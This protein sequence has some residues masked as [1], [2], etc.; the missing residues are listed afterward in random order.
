MGALLSFC[1]L[2]VF[3]VAQVEPESLADLVLR[4]VPILE[5]CETR[6]HL[7][8]GGRWTVS[9]EATFHF[10]YL[11]SPDESDLAQEFADSLWPKGVDRG[12]ASLVGRGVQRTNR[13]RWWAQASSKKSSDMALLVRVLQ[14]QLQ[15]PDCTFSW[16]NDVFEL[17]GVKSKRRRG[18]STGSLLGDIAVGMIVESMKLRFQADIEKRLTELAVKAASPTVVDLIDGWNYA[19]ESSRIAWWMLQEMISSRRIVITTSGT[20]S[21]TKPATVDAEGKKI[22]IDAALLEGGEYPELSIRIEGLRPR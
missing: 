10:E 19:R 6:I 9:Q 8:S 5:T 3:V 20:L 21:S 17:Q 22:T 15:L 14:E 16:N 7:G 1:A 18:D 12:G 2:S 4:D 11:Q 13:F